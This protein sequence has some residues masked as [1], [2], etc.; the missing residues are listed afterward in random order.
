MK[1]AIYARVST[2]EQTQN[3]SIENQLD[4]LRKFCQQHGYELVGEYVDP[5]W[6]GA[7]LQ[8]PELSRLLQDAKAKLFDVVVVYK[9]DRLFRSNRHMYNTLAEWENTGVSLVSVT[10]PF[11]TSTTMGKA[12]LGMA[13]TFAEWERNTFMERSR[14]GVRKSVEKGHYSGGIVA[15]GYRLNPETKKLEIQENE[16]EVVRKMFH[17]LNEEGMSCYKIA[18]ALNA[19]GIPT[20]YAK[21]GRG[22]RGKA[23]AGIWRPGR[24]Y[25]MLRNSAYKGEW[26]YGRRSKNTRA[27]LISG[28][29][30]AIVDEATFQKAQDRLKAN[31][32]WA[33]RNCKRTYLLRGLIKCDL[34]GH[35]YSG[36]CNHTT[37]KGELRYY[38]CNRNGN[39]GNLL[40]SECAAPSIRADIVENLIWQ[41]IIEFIQQPEVVREHLK[42]KLNSQTVNWEAESLGVDKRMGELMEAERRL[43][44]LY[45]D[46]RNNFSEE[47]LKTELEEITSA[48]KLIL[49]RKQELEEARA[50]EEW[51]IRKL[52]NVE[53]VLLRLKDG[54]ANATPQ[55]K[56]E[57]IENLVQ[58]VRVGKDADGITVLNI[59][60][61]FGN[62]LQTQ[63]WNGELQATRMSLRL[64]RRP[65][66][67]MYLFP[68]AG[69]TLPEADQRASSGPYRYLC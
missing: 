52:E 42:A 41:Q 7:T 3:F 30:P 50:S 20:S 4:H 29:C 47:A 45:T 43:L 58:E 12:Y 55:V 15:Y 19:L 49:R 61:T 17:M 5:G 1:A 54:I 2:E 69:F 18:P 36:C 68:D 57:V 9:L 31:C 60:Y 16:A 14:D 65:G 22:I 11:E 24:V 63:Q 33:D 21:D 38:R 8:R 26:V 46:P 66:K 32:L 6:S 23:T 35:A 28:Q 62:D 10:E 64:L 27:K 39:R 34:C 37:P 67:A 13:S 25:N 44:R 51:Q 53:A 48:K 59:V 56:R 40:S